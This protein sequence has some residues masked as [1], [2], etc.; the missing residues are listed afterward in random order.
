MAAATIARL[1]GIVI[2]GATSYNVALLAPEIAFCVLSTV[3]IVLERRRRREERG[4]PTSE[5]HAAPGK[6][7][8]ALHL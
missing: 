7:A 3:G 1:Q 5:R 8:M 6:R 4:G 2:D